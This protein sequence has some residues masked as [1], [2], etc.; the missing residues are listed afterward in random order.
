MKTKM[1]V[2][3][4]SAHLSIVLAIGLLAGLALSAWPF[5]TGSAS[6]TIVVNSFEDRVNNDGFCTLREAIIAANKDKSS[7]RLAGECRAGSGTDTINVPAGV[8]TLTRTDSGNEDAAATG[9]LDIIG[10]VTIQ[11]QNPGV[12]IAAVSGFTDRIFHIL[13]GQVTINAVTIKGGRVNGNGGGIYNA[14]SLTMRNNTIQNN[15]ATGNG[16]GIYNAGTLVVENST[17]SGNSSRLSGGGL[18]NQGSASLGY[19]TIS[20][21]TALDG[22]GGGVFIS[23]GALTLRSSIIAAN[24]DNSSSPLQNDCSGPLVS[25]GHNLIQDITGCTI[26]G[27]STGNIAGQSA[28]LGP[29]A[30]NGGPT[31]THAL[32]PGSP[33]IDAGDNNACPAADQRGFPRPQGA[34]CDMGAYE[35]TPMAQ[36]GPIYTVNTAADAN[37]GLCSSTDCSLRE[38]IQTANGHANG[39]SPDEIHFN[40][41]P[42]GAL[43]LQ[44]AS[45]L[46]AITDPLVIDGATQPGGGVTL[47]GSAAGAGVDGVAIS[48]GGSTVRSMTIQGFSGSAIVLSGGGNNLIQGNTLTQ[49]GGSGV[50]VLSG[51]G[52]RINANAI[53]ANGRLGIDLG[54][55]GV[56]A[57]NTGSPGVNRAQNFAILSRA[58]PQGNGLEVQGRLHGLANAAYTLEFYG[59]PSC[60]ASAYGEGETLA[61]S[62]Q[63]STDG[64]G[65]AQFNFTLSSSLAAG[66]FVT[67]IA[68]GPDGSSSEF[69]QCIAA[70]P[71]NDAWTNALRLTLQPG[72][73][74]V[75]G[76]SAQGFIDK[77]GRSRWYKFTVKPGSRLVVTLT[78]LPANYDLTLY[79]DITSAF[80]SLSSTQDL[81]RLGAEFAPDAFSPDAFSPDAFS[82]D[83]FSPDAF[84]P[85]AF[86]P[87]AFSPDAFSPDAFSPDAFSPDAFSPDAFSPDAFSPDAFSPDAF[88]PDAFSPDAFSPDAFSPD[89][90]SGAQ[91]RSLIAVSAFNGLASEGILVNTWDQSGDYY[92]RVRGRNG[93]YSLDGAF[94]LAVEQL[95]GSCSAVSADLPPSS[96]P[97]SAGGY[98]T[99]LLTDM[100]RMTGTDAEKNTLRDRL[101]ALAS[102]P[103]VAGVIVDVGQDARV[104]AANRQADANPAC[105]FAKN[106]VAGAVQSLIAAY[107]T[108]NPLEYVVIVGNDS[109]IPFFRY[110]D[111]AQIAS[112][113]N[114]VPPVLDASASQAS[115]KLGYLL[116]QDGYG[117]QGQVSI[118]DSS[119]PIPGLAVGRLVETPTDAT[120]I[121]DAYLGTPAGVVPAPAS[122]LVTGYDFLSD[123]ASAVQS[124]LEAGAGVPADTLIAPREQSPADPAAWTADDLRQALLGSR[125][126]LIFLAGHFSA[127]SALAADYRTR[128]LS[129][130]LLASPVD[131]TNA[132]IFSAGCHA[133]YN[134]V[135]ADAITG[136]TPQPDW[137]QT[138]ARKG[139]TLI[140]GTGYQYGDTDFI[141]YSERLYLEFS[142][143][144]RA[145]SGPVAVGKALQ[146]A[147]QAYLAGTPVLRGIHEKALLESTLFGLPMLRVNMPQGRGNP[148]G[149][150]SIVPSVTPFA[151]NPGAA[152]GLAF[153]DVR[154]TPDLTS[155]SVEMKDPPDGPIYTGVY[156]SGPDGVVANPAEPVLPLEMD[157]VA[158]PGTLLRGVGFRGGSYADQ[159][160]VLPLTGAATTEVRGVHA[161]FIS[162]VF[163]PIQPWSTNYFD[164]LSNPGSGATRLVLTPAQLGATDPASGLS[165]LR[166]FSAM[167]FRLFY[168]SNT[169][170]YGGGSIPALSAPPSIV[171][172]TGEIGSDAV[173]FRVRVTGNPAAGIQSVWVTYTALAGPYA[174]RWQPLDLVQSPGDSTLWEGTLDLN[175]ASAQDVRFMVQAANGVGLVSMATNLG[176][177]YRP[178]IQAEPASTA[179]SLNAPVSTGPYGSQASF[180][181]VLTS[182]GAPLSGEMITFSLGPQ[183]RQALTDGSGRAEVT[184]GLLGLPGDHQVKVSFGGTAEYAPSSDARS[185]TISRQA[186]QITL[187]PASATG[188]ANSP[189]LMV[190]TLQDATGR[191]LGEKTVFF[192]VSGSGGQ[193]AL[194]VIT[195]Y[196]GRAYLGGLSLPDG[197]YT[198]VA[199][200]GGL[201]QLPGGISL[202]LQDDRYE[203]SSASGDLTIL[204]PNQPPVCLA[205]VPNRMFIW[206]PNNSTFKPVNVLGVTDPD[207]DP[208]TITVTSIFQ[209]EPVGTGTYSPDGYGVGGTT[210]FVR[211]ERDGSQDGRVYHIS[212]TASDG[213]GGSC[214]GEVRVAI[215]HD[216]GGGIDPIDGGALYDST[217]PG[218]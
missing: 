79:K 70:G 87:D 160:G 88:S 67:S 98:H 183:S 47:L 96:L 188:Y 179:I 46:P 10:S 212:F 157:N 58:I 103:E 133:G 62:A 186:T 20:A 21:N 135:D 145:G 194:P 132:L 60:D 158:V 17:F 136:V 126:D 109:V 138:F 116:S 28:N 104:S 124:E 185:F 82:P 37:D 172:V 209:D 43:A 8:Y 102:R 92:V 169:Q 141:E 148:G 112:E 187:D 86:S 204:P 196:A 3:R 5:S 129:T 50:S 15:T 154:L 189:D 7:G 121:V 151:S 16:G 84:S 140:A 95:A 147:K 131:L 111:Q 142:R 94:D 83:A 108:R 134:I 213:L 146:D 207:G 35:A 153:A 218:P 202:N 175:G 149:D 24:R 56:T 64:N 22:S 215:A 2:L 155:Q 197:S 19:V 48:A 214:S 53:S 190:A 73:P 171:N 11:G 23:S 206:P 144:L 69:S 76:A 127:S 54:G 27:D 211:V 77:L 119:F 191:P 4:F 170:T 200:F 164:L 99:I 18:A 143:Q 193:Q 120:G 6:A 61:G 173:A 52:N 201:I 55:D 195:D 78:D 184:M 156:L 51:S 33:A 159:P 36:S 1:G 205:A 100:A 45:A 32:L 176:A 128:L 199:R 93:V 90:F 165:T 31:W 107:Q 89:A 130:E 110:P 39:A 182:G 40:V 80:T 68:T 29:L 91:S 168:S 85:D 38:A 174:G 14:G 122:L 25:A 66:S 13:S 59:N 216:Q 203:P 162:T 167:D 125:H 74:G 208:I 114:Y 150:G 181:A 57:E 152:L 106:L 44:P 65:N 123:A 177:Y 101:V 198:V 75:E 217:V 161:P 180:S 26:S 30:D 12:T 192:L 210:A 137:A 115:L 72:L 118:K 166:S 105:P 42:S 97:V 117:A 163:Y 63:T 9:D 71:G 178:G 113:K 34:G 49:N 81:A 139:A 41:P